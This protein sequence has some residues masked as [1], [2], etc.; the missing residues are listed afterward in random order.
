MISLLMKIGILAFPDFK[1]LSGQLSSCLHFFG[2]IL[3]GY[4]GLALGIGELP[5]NLLILMGISS[6]TYAVNKKV[7]DMK[8][9]NDEVPH[10]SKRPKKPYPLR[11]MLYENDKQ[12]LTR[13]QYFAWTWVSIV[14]YLLL[15]TLAMIQVD[16]TRDFAGLNVPDIIPF[17]VLLMGI[18]Q[19]AFIGGKFLSIKHIFS[20]KNVEE[21]E[22]EEEE[23]ERRGKEEEEES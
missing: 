22:E 21:E 20:G 16:M 10:A 18:G 7:S 12:S 1:Y 19:G 17:L 6:A 2:Y 5:Y 8:Y 23:E 15:L 3:L 13:V 11:S 4:V 9:N 14:V